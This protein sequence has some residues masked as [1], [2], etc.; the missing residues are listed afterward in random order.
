VD[1]IFDRPRVL[2]LTTT[3]PA[4]PGDG[5]PEFVLSLSRSLAR[6]F[7]ITI[8][9]PRVRGARS[10]ESIGGL[11]IYRFPYF[12]RRWEGLADGAILSNLSAQRWR[13]V[14]APF[15]VIS[16]AWHALRLVRREKPDAVHAHWIVPAGLVALFLKKVRGTPY[17]LTVHGADAYGLQGRAFERLKRLIVKHAHAVSPVSGDIATRFGFSPEETR[18]FVV[19]MGVEFDDIERMVGERTPIQGRLLFVGRLAEKKGVDVLIR[20]IADVPE[21]ALRIVGD[22]PERPRLE[23][24]ADEFGVRERVEF[25]GQVPR[26]GV[27]DEFRSAQALVIPSRIARSGDREGTPVVMAEAMAAGVPIIAS[28]LGGLA[29]HIVSEVTGALVEPDSAPDLSEGIRRAM[30]D[31]EALEG[32]ARA[33]RDAMRETLDIGVTASR[34]GTFL[35]AAVREGNRS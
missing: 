27:L 35:D 28:R 30:Q 25:L 33:A 31:G 24:L 21:A 11:R 22:G 14:E 13:L 6:S 12:P 32:W 5:T 9:S 15:L 1:T 29:E 34:Y 3:L 17:V 8:L 26:T 4:Q 18:R 2:V 10:D 7:R 19:P 16:F 20:A 23:R